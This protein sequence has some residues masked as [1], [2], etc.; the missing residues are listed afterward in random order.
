MTDSQGSGPRFVLITNLETVTIG[1]VRTWSHALLLQDDGADE[2]HRLGGPRFRARGFSYDAA[3]PTFDMALESIDYTIEPASSPHWFIGD[4]GE[5]K[6][7]SRGGIM[8]IQAPVLDREVEMQLVAEIGNEEPLDIE[9]FERPAGDKS[10]RFY[11]ETLWPTLERKIVQYWHAPFFL[12]RTQVP[13]E[14]ARYALG[15]KGVRRGR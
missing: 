11:S 10:G 14:Q 8:R 7:L 2:R 6:P 1:A 13:V 5:A 9:V 12:A 15:V 3:T 4:S